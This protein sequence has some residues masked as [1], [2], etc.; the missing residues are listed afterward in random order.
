MAPADPGRHGDQRRVA[1]RRRR[2]PGPA[3]HGPQN[4]QPS[5]STTFVPIVTTLK[6]DPTAA[7]RWQSTANTWTASFGS[8]GAATALV[9]VT[10]T[11]VPLG[12]TAVG[13]SSVAPSVSGSTATYTGLW[14][15]VNATYVVTTT[16]VNENLV[17]T[18]AAAQSTFDFDLTDNS[19]RPARH[20]HR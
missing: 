20:D 14:P 9:Q 3:L 5:G 6:A 12:F 18:S 11:A 4:Y 10:G 1:G 2:H 16:G 15:D 8:S 19:D 17:L 7:G 13:A